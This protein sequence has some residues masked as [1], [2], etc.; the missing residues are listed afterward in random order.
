LTAVGFVTRSDEIGAVGAVVVGLSGIAAGAALIGNDVAGTSRWA[1]RAAGVALLVGMPMGIAWSLA[2][3]FGFA[4]ID[5]ETMVRTHGALNAAA[6]LF[7]TLA[8][9]R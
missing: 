4:F 6:V 8:A 7:A 3:L 5:L 1:L 9:H 2:I